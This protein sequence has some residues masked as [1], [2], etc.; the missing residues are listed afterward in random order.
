MTNEER[1]QLEQS[2]KAQ[3]R[4][5]RAIP[6]GR[7]YDAEFILKNP[8]P[9]RCAGCGYHWSER[10]AIKSAT[11]RNCVCFWCRGK[12]IA[13]DMESYTERLK[14]L[15]LYSIPYQPELSFT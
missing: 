1:E 13:L 11:L 10:D 15:H 5:E 2:G 12:L 4:I 7:L 3:R 14:N 9:A 6:L 8:I